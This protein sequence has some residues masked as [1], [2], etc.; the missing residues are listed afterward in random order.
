MRRAA[1]FAIGLAL[2]ALPSVASPRE[3]RPLRP[4]ANPS[5]VIAAELAFARMARERG[6]WTAFRKTAT[7]DA[8]W[9]GPKWESV[10]SSLKGKADPAQAI[11][12]EPD[13]VWA[14]CDGSFALSSGPATYPGGSRG[15]FA[16]IWQRQADG[17]YRWVL[18]QGFDL[19][20]GYDAP[21]MIPARVAECRP[22]RP[23]KAAKPRRGE[24]WQAGRSDDGSL[25]WDTALAADCRRTFVVNALRDGEMRE[26]FRRV[27]APPA[28]ANC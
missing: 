23:R 17:E 18:D 7:K 3:R 9:P 27:S 22:Q 16:T 21:G 25:S 28:A 26:V 13:I 5:A 6:Q 15:R 8:V 19:E 10:Q 24:P 11:V 14:S 2:L 20:A 1:A 4:V 12:W